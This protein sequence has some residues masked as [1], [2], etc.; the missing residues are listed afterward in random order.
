M[1]LSSVKAQRLLEK[2]FPIKEFE[3]VIAKFCDSCSKKPELLFRYHAARELGEHPTYPAFYIL[4][5]VSSVSAHREQ[6]LI[7]DELYLILKNWV[8]QPKIK[9]ELAK[10]SDISIIK[11]AQD[12]LAHKTIPENVKSG[13]QLGIVRANISID[14]DERDRIILKKLCARY[15]EILKKHYTAAR[16]W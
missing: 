13:M 5:L 3:V 1:K 2:Y 8:E 7:L 14:F 15:D 9:K 11:E 10:Y 12:I 4:S 6:S 16:E